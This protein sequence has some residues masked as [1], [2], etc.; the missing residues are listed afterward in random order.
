[1]RRT[2]AAALTVVAVSAPGIA[3]AAEKS[4][5]R[6]PM[7]G[8]L[9]Q[10]PRKV[11]FRDVNLT[12]LR[13]IHWGWTKA[14]ARG[15]ARVLVCEPS[16]ADGYVV[17]GKVRLVVRKRVVEGDRRVY[18]CIEGRITGV[19]RSVSRISWMC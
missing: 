18:Q 15:N 9:A 6:D 2:L 17:R 12:G 3:H 4:Y 7:T 13:W 19:P 14:I 11:D 10:K 16:C 8:R 5:V 1:M